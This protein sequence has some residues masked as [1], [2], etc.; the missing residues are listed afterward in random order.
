MKREVTEVSRARFAMRCLT[1]LACLLLCALAVYGQGNRGS[2]TGTITDPQGGVT[3]NA[4]IDVKNADTG[5]LFHGGTSSTGNYV[6]PVPAGKYEMTVSVTGFKKY[7]RTNIEVVTATDT[8][9]DVKLE[10]GATT[11]TIT[12]TEEAPLLKT[13]SG[14]L[15]HTMTTND[16][17]QLPL[18]TTNGSGGS[19]G[20][21][22]IRNPLQEVLLLPGTG[23]VN[24]NA[25]VVNGLPANSENIRIEGQDS[26]SNIWKIAQQNS[27]GG[28]DAIQEVAVQTSNF[29]AEY[30]Q[31][32]GGYFNY[33]MKSGTNQFHGSG[34]DYF[35]NEGLNAGTP[36][37]DRCTQSGLYCTDTAD[38][39]HIRNRVRRNDYGFTVGGP[40]WIPKV[41]NG[42]NKSFFF[43]NFEQ[44]R[45]NNLNGTTTTT[46]PTPAYRAGNF[47]TALCS[48]YIGG[49]ADGTGG[50][51]VPYPGVTQGGKPAVDTNNT[52]LV[53]G[54]IFN[55]YST[56]IV[57]GQQVRTPFSNNTIPASLQDPVSLAIQKFLPLPNA[58]G[59]TNNYNVPAYRSFQHTT[60]VSVKMDQS[61]SSTIKISGYYSQL[62]T[63]SPNVNGGITPLFLGGADTNQ[64]NHTTRLNYDQTITPTLL[65][66][67]GIGYFQ[68]SEPHVAPPFDQSTLGLKG[69]FANNIF[70]DLSGLVGA[71]GGYGNAATLAGGVGSTFSATAYEEK[72][73]ANTSL[74]W[75]RGNH[76]FK[77]G[78]DYTQEGYPVPSLWR[79]N[80]NF[81]FNAAETS[82]PWQF[83]QALSATNPTG[84]AYA[85]FMTGL[86]DVL[87]LNA[88]TDIRLGYHSLGV[89]LQ[90]SW[91]VTRK[92]TVDYGLRYDYQTFMKEQYGRM[93]DA[94]FSTF[95]PVTGHNGAVLYGATC[96]CEFSHNYPYA[97][98]PRLGFAYQID[99]K[100]VIRGGGGIQYDVAEAPNG[101]L[102]SAADYYTINPNGY[103]ISPM[104]NTA[105]PA[106]NGLQGGN[107][108]A[109][110]NPY[111]NV[112]VV[113]PN[114]NQNKYPF[115]NNG[116]AAPT[117]GASPFVFF[118]PQNRPGRTFTW[119][120]GVQREVMKNLVAEIAY[121]GNRGSW[122]PAPNMDQIAS[123]SLTPALL[124]SQFGID[125]NNPNDRALLTDQITNPAV[126]A[127]FPQ[128][129]TV[130]VNGTLTVPSI[131]PGFPASQTLQQA[132]RNVPQ[133][134]GVSPWL[135]PPLGKTWYDSMQVKVTKRYSHGLQA[136]GNFTWAKGL[137]NGAASDSTYY[138]T[139]QA[140]TTDIYNYGDNKQLNQ[141]VRPLAM[142]ITFS[143]TTP[144]FSATGFGMKL[145]SQVTRDWQLSSVLRYQSGAL[146]ALPASLNQLTT[147][148][149][150]TNPLGFT[151]TFGNNYWNLT[152]QPLLKFDPNCGCFN[153][154][155][156]GVF[157]LG[158]FTDAPSGTWSNSAPF[159]NNFR[160]QR[161]PA[162]SLAFARNFRLGPAER[163]YVLQIRAEFQNIFNRLFLAPPGVANTNP[164]L[165]IVTTT[166]AGQAINNSGFGSVATLNG[167]GATG[168]Q[169]RSGQIIARFT[170]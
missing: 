26:T 55:P 128:F 5:E 161:Q 148:L 122:F 91:K 59:D 146:I 144:K 40:V 136:Q 159:Y 52:P 12:V 147:Q 150:R 69:Y 73:T 64:W 70:P 19:T 21:G 134:G 117:Q 119:S 112:P 155:T 16:V 170:F 103:G 149:G 153:P 14:E 4:A 101:V 167:G 1:A 76:T 160:W 13:E 163:N 106:Q 68:T 102:Y 116:I 131:Y 78:G 118:D 41:Y 48:S 108:Y 3:P 123:N 30:G 80:G 29:N 36:F 129:K 114:L 135:G 143:Y 6:I 17:T 39:Q 31:A 142:T 37:T 53:Q 145:L 120:I 54:M 151:N 25:L 166:Y 97:F 66:H 100:T 96:K 139:G 61:L 49:A 105:N 99:T 130:L 71:Q 81:T 11:E 84:F 72:P 89:F 138:L 94:S 65:F 125:F 23:F 20:N 162:E 57:G 8:R 127:R 33:T 56:A 137:V 44:F 157:N 62:N 109:P 51:C 10:L 98:G 154:Q 32:A 111:G 86:P 87:Q 93:Q 74:T 133:W 169:P 121:V 82:D 42:R 9:Q 63:F 46:V 34:Y 90:D 124:L 7:V 79:A 126:Q 95:D 45:Q 58:P 164:N 50:T 168:A 141:Y 15:S 85:S 75:V 77:A 60:N 92:L 83:G 140:L 88:P 18:L 104:Q 132:L 38:R 43:V 22:N 152:G 156:T 28:V 113:W 24:D 110:G 35:V 2:I 158:A 47:S 165:P 115:F 27:Q 67:V 107:P